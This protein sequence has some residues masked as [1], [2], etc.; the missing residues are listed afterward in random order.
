MNSWQVLFKNVVEQFGIE[1]LSSFRHKH[2][3]VASEFDILN[4]QEILDVS[5]SNC[6][7]VA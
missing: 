3:K 5:S 7:S 4:S 2:R 6:L 1:T